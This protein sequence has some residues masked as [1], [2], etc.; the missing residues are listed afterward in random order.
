M[1]VFKEGNQGDEFFVLDCTFPL[2][3]DD[4][5]VRLLSGVPGDGVD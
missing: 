4:G 5:I 1:D 2:F 3:E